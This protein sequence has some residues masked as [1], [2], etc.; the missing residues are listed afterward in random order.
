MLYWREQGYICAYCGMELAREKSHIEN[1]KLREK[2]PNLA[3]DY[4]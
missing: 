3:L 4:H 1:L 2:Y